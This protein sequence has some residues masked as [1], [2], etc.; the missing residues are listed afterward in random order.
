MAR[1]MGIET[2]P[3]VVAYATDRLKAKLERSA[4]YNPVTEMYGGFLSYRFLKE[5]HGGGKVIYAD[6]YKRRQLEPNL[7]RR[8]TIG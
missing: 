7:P 2:G 5:M 4:V 6:H 1:K 3:E 8:P